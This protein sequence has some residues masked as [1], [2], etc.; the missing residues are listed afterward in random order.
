M[1]ISV[2][3]IFGVLNKILI[4]SVFLGQ[5]FIYFSFQLHSAQD[6]QGMKPISV[7]VRPEI[8]LRSQ[9]QRV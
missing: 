7:T 5:R 4:K 9:E 8:G 2:L 6:L 1:D 3:L